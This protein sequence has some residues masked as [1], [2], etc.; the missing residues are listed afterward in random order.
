VC[1][2]WSSRQ[3]CR[4]CRIS[5]RQTRIIRGSGAVARFIAGECREKGGSAVCL[6]ALAFAIENKLSMILARRCVVSLGAGAALTGAAKFRRV[7]RRRSIIAA[8][9]WRARGL[10]VVQ[11]RERYRRL[12]GAAPSP[13][14]FPP[15]LPPRPRPCPR[16]PSPL[17]PLRP[18]SPSSWCVS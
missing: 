3:I 16:P 12:R 11:L 14:P 8:R 17:P 15:H 18:R 4:V 5:I 13:P 9:S 7:A 1:G 10:L 6:L 2:C